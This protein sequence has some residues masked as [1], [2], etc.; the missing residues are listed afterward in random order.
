M[1]LDTN[2]CYISRDVIFI[3]NTFPFSNT[4]N[5][6]PATDSPLFHTVQPNAEV[7]KQNF[8]IVDIP[9]V[10]P[11]SDTV[12]L[13]SDSFGSDFEPADQIPINSDTTNVTS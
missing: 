10:T 2:K 3:E 5:C 4:P 13:M 7:T 8:T 11:I 9:T 12:T 1:H 6:T